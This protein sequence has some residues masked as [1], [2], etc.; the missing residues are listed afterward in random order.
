MIYVLATHRNRLHTHLTPTTSPFSHLCYWCIFGLYEPFLELHVS[1]PRNFF[2]NLASHVQNAYNS[3]G[4][5]CL[6]QTTSK[7]NRFLGASDVTPWW[8][9]GIS[10]SD[11]ISVKNVSALLF[12]SCQPIEIASTPIRYLQLLHFH[13][14]AILTRRRRRRWGKRTTVNKKPM[15]AL[16]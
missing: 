13:I 4:A 7:A 6:T 11:D 8:T 9:E 1:V 5:P 12:M 10:Y 14:L 15:L 2:T 16:E 3:L